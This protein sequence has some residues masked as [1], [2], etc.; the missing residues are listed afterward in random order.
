M[1]KKTDGSENIVVTGGGPG[2]HGQN[3]FFQHHASRGD[4]AVRSH[5]MQIAP[6]ALMV[7][8]AFQL[9]DIAGDFRPDIGI[10]GRGGK[11]LKLT[12]LG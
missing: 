11:A 4:P 10:H 8:L 1:K 7:Q 12:K 6:Y 5:N 9:I 3:R 2:Q